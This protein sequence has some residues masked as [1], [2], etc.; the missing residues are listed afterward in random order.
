[1]VKP[2]SVADVLVNSVKSYI[3]ELGENDV[4]VFC[5]G[6]NDVS[7]N[8]AKQVLRNIKNFMMNNNHTNIILVSIPHRHDLIENSCVNNEIRAVNKKLMKYYQFIDDQL[9]IL[10]IL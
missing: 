4:I 7:K 10:C 1:V 3:S 8:N 2:G 6:A 5:G 9:E